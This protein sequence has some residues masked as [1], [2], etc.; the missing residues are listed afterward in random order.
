MADL[1]LVEA[2]TRRQLLLLL[3]GGNS[4]AA[5]TDALKG[6]SVRQLGAKPQGLP[7]SIWQLAEHI[8]VVQWDILKLS[9]NPQHRSPKWPEG[10]WPKTAAPKDDEEWLNCVD[11]IYSDRQKFIDLL[12]DTDV[13]I[14]EPFATEQQ[15][16][17]FKFALMMADH[18][19]YHTG[20]IV[21]VRR[22]L[23]AW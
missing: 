12:S 10:Y 7:Y 22:L 15:E 3:N 23:N 1:S 11:Q 21:L 9:T 6:L 13:D 19:S 5:L 2:T 4:H 17:I 8:R 18:T 14:F 16:T 20:Q